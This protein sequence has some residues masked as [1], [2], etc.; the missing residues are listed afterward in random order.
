MTQMLNFYTL[1]MSMANSHSDVCL[2]RRTKNL[3]N[4]AKQYVQ[5]LRSPAHVVWFTNYL[6]HLHKA[7]TG[8]STRS[9]IVTFLLRVK[10]ADDYQDHLY[11]LSIED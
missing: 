2:S 10:V 8:V 9:N 7:T 4:R 5:P 11:S 3:I 6:Q 1:W